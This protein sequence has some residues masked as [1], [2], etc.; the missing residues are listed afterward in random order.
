[1]ILILVG[2]SRANFRRQ[3]REF[4]LSRTAHSDNLKLGHNGNSV[5][6]LVSKIDIQVSHSG[7]FGEPME[8]AVMMRVHLHIL[9]DHLYQVALNKYL[10]HIGR[11]KMNLSP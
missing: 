10:T 2:T 9:Q 5:S 1:M 8:L 11:E 3:T 4:L 6:I 7:G